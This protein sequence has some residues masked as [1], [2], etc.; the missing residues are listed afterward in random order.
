[1]PGKYQGIELLAQGRSPSGRVALPCGG[2][3]VI[4]GWTFWGDCVL[5]FYSTTSKTSGQ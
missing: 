5:S 1:M 2:A 3:G 4:F